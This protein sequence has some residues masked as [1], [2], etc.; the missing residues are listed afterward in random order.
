MLGCPKDLKQWCPTL[1][2]GCM[3]KTY[4]EY[5]QAAREAEKEESMELSWNPWSQVI[6]NIAKPKTTSFFPLQK[7]KGN[8]PVSK[9]ATV[10]LVHLEEESA[11]RGGRRN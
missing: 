3:K 6:D 7:L 1:K 4:S 2:P 5:L 9:T 11:E 10:H 8:Q